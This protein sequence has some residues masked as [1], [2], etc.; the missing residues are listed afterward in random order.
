[1]LL[2]LTSSQ[3]PY[4]GQTLKSAMNASGLTGIGGGVFYMNPSVM[5]GETINDTVVFAVGWLGR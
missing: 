2:S 1:M 4:I 3:K 5:I